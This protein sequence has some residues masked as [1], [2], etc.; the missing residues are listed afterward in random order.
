MISQQ[1]IDRVIAKVPD[2][3]TFMTV[4]EMD[5]SS[6]KLA[7]AHPD[8]VEIFE[9]TKSR[10]GHPLYCLKIGNGSQN[11]ICYGCP[12][13]NEPIGAMMLEAFS[14]ILA[15]DAELRE[16]L[17]YTWYIIK[18]WDVDGTQLNEPWFKGPFSLKNYV[19]HFFRPAPTAQV[20]W[21]FPIDYKNLHF[22]DSI[23]ETQAVQKLIDEL[24]PSFLYS[25]HNSAFGGVYWYLTEAFDEDFYDMLRAVAAKHGMPI[26]LGEPEAP[27]IQRFSPAVYR[28]ISMAD[29]YDYYESYGAEHPEEMCG[30]GT[31]S[32][33]YGKAA[34]GAFTLLTELPYFFN[35][36][37]CDLS[38]SDISRCDANLYALDYRKAMKDFAREALTDSWGYIDPANPFKFAVEGFNSIDD[39]SATRKMLS[40]NPEYQKPATIAE[41][42]SNIDL[43][44]FFSCLTLAL[45]TRAHESELE[46]MEETGEIN[47]AKKEALTKAFAL[48]EAKLN[49]QAALAE[50]KLSYEVVPIRKLISIQLEA[51][52]LTASKVHP[53]AK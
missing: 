7:E 38:A 13:P 4:D 25:L 39:D 17:D 12:H 36:A 2:Y 11:A 19:R 5:A 14:T 50:E 1:L 29:S 45:Y 23:P 20:D 31:C 24:S 41:K 9:L 51:G 53:S 34:C 27:Y 18:S 16:A 22:H 42:F 8:V 37:I 44:P 28:N 46:H 40:E 47:P 43:Q 52:L 21:T 3:Q 10:A 35:P 6:H 33:D 26:D 30:C 49:E 32:A 48:F 15:E